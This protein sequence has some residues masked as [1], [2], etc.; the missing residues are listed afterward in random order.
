MGPEQLAGLARA[1]H[2]LGVVLWIG[3]VAF[4][5]MIV[6]PS[7]KTLDSDRRVVLFEAIER[8]FMRVARTMILVVGA[9]GYYLVSSFDLWDRFRHPSYWWMDA[10]VVVW[11]IFAVVLFI[12]EPLFLRRRFAER[13]KSAPDRTIASMQRFHWILLAASVITILGA[14][15][16][17]HGYGLIE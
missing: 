9:T 10:M 4:V 3:G 16:G 6:L 8:R 15:A 5:T 2:V 13:L 14:A 1:F 7:L 11:L 12:A 17:A